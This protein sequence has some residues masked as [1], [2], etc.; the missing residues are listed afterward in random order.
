MRD[1]T[2]N[3]LPRSTA[4]H[5]R[6]ELSWV[7]DSREELVQNL[8]DVTPDP[9]NLI[10]IHVY[11][12]GQENRFNQ[13][14][15]SY[16]EILQLCMKAS[17]Q[18]GKGLFVGEF[19][20]ADDEKSGGPEKARVEFTKLLAAIGEAGVPLSALWV[21][22]LPFQDSFV[23]V[24]PANARSWQLDELEKANHRLKEMGYQ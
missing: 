9:M 8:I 13:P 3:S 19:G 2:G 5:Q 12:F 11:P 20:A 6:R 16:L 22:D 15:P 10:S 4:E 1:H 21:F 14:A 23:S 17:A 24:T 7:Q 18:S